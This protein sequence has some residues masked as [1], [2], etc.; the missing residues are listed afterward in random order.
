MDQ[1]H[2]HTHTSQVLEC[3]S[4]N[5][6]T[7]LINLIT[8]TFY[9]DHEITVILAPYAGWVLDLVYTQTGLRKNSKVSKP[10]FF[11]W[12]DVFNLVNIITLTN[13]Q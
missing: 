8:S 4:E 5:R 3:H 9:Q 6:K 7:F 10:S 2:M 13:L 1:L 12:M 11:N